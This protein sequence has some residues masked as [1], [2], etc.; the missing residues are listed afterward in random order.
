MALGCIFIS[1]ARCVLVLPKLLAISV[2]QKFILFVSVG[3]M[4]E[5]ELRSVV[6]FEN[7]WLW[8]KYGMTVLI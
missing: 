5:K 7:I 2:P 3:H 4:E 6:F 1:I 8:V